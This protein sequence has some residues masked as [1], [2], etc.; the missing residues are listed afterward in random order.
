MDADEAVVLGAG[1]F[2]ANLSTIF[3]LRKFGMTDKA[4]YA[5][6]FN[7]EGADED[8]GQQHTEAAETEAAAAT[9]GPRVLVPALK[10]IPTKRA[11]A[12]HNLTTD[13]FS[14]S[15]EMDN[16]A[17]AVLPCCVRQEELGNFQIEG[18]KSVVDKYGY[19]GK[20]AVHTLVDQSGVF[21]IDRA[22]ASVEIEEEMKIKVAPPPSSAANDTVSVPA[23][24]E[25][26]SP[27][28]SSD[29]T[30]TEN[31]T[32]GTGTGGSSS[33]SS[34]STEENE[35]ATTTP[36][37]E[38][39]EFT[40][41]KW[42]RTLRVPLNITGSFLIPSLTP[43]QRAASRRILRM[44]RERDEIKRATAKARN[45]LEAYVI[46]TRDKLDS[47][48]GLKAVS[49]EEQREAIFSALMDAEDWL[50]GDGDGADATELKSRLRAVRKGGD[51]IEF[52]AAE[53]A[54]R[55]AAVDAAL[56]FVELAMKA[57]NAWPTMKPWLNETEV[58]AVVA[59]VE[60]F[61]SWVNTSAAE[62][63]TRAAHEDPVFKVTDVAVRMDPVK[64][65]FNRV[66]TKTKPIE[67]PPPKIV[68]IDVK[69]GNST[70]TSTS[71][72]GVGMEKET[73]PD[74]EV[75][76]EGAGV[77]DKESGGDGAGHDEL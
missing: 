41:K 37:E 60:E 30:P 28:S 20:V 73:I 10:K 6:T 31:G 5:V 75:V 57:V 27:A 7:L 58:A 2:A 12:L 38:E 9:T 68:E 39:E 1:L 54:A 34:S 48:D 4:P 25:G 23:G 59:A 18:I 53:A 62:Q 19:S 36:K 56:S 8:T 42:K 64:K 24:E 63:E 21:H 45:D 40:T 43:E 49:T 52:R 47:D 67:K 77:V 17:G 15:F 50:Y 74:E 3:R 71:D 51:A 29:D 46:N 35:A 70:T 11:I 72:D 14:V 55:H 32:L 76:E 61:K 13:S 33:S 22:D 69:E 44:L 65:M 26:K 16:S 66:N